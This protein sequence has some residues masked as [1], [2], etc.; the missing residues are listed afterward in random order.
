MIESTID[1]EIQ[2]EKYIIHIDVENMQ[3]QENLINMIKNKWSPI[4]NEF[5]LQKKLRDLSS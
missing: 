2:N 3:S 4:P 1:G 5:G